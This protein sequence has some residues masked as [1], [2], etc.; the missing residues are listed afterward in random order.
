MLYEDLVSEIRAEFPDFEVIPKSQSRLMLL[1]DGI[2]RVLTFGRFRD[3]MWSYTTT[4]GTKVYTP[5]DWG[6]WTNATRNAIL[7]HERVHMRQA[8][9][10]TR[11]GF[12]LAYLFLPL[13]FGL[14]YCR[15]KFEMEAYEE[16][17]R[18]RYELLGKSG[19][20]GDFRESILSQFTGPAYLWMWPFRSYLE[21]W[22]DGVVRTL[23]A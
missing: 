4:L 3:F 23:T 5:K 17:I 18:A 1:I 14:A 10:Y 19:L 2:L 6:L 21:R 12:S 11:L 15:A 20:S 7:R 13:P 22:Y 9:R 8:R 16:S